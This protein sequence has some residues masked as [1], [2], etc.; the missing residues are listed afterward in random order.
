MLSRL[1]KRWGM[2]FFTN[3]FIITIQIFC[4]KVYL[5]VSM[6]VSICLYEKDKLKI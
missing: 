5:I 3:P 1:K 6:N 2:S 4:A